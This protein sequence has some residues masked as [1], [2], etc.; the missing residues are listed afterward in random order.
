MRRTGRAPVWCGYCLSD[1][2]GFDAWEA[3]L[4]CRADL[5]ARPTFLPP[6][7]GNVTLLTQLHWPTVHPSLQE[8][9]PLPA[10]RLWFS[11]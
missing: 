1:Y 9:R 10:G 6:V 11:G 8:S 5:G 4:P 7:G 3:H 2:D